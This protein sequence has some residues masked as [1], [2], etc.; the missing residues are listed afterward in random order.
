VGGHSFF[1]ASSP[2]LRFYARSNYEEEIAKDL[3]AP[4][5]FDKKFF[6]QRFS[7]DDVR[8]FKPDVTID[9]RTELNIGGTR[10]ELIPVEGGETHDSMFVHFPDLGA[11]FVGDF[12]MPYLGAPFLA[13]GNLP[14]LLDAID[15][16]VDKQPRHLLHGHEPLT[17]NFSS[18]SILARLKTHLVWLREQVLSAIRRGDERAAIHQANLIPPG[19]RVSSVF[20]PA[21]TRC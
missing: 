19:R 2:R 16:V 1:R 3:N 14:G 6:G 17:R 4:G 18:S 10:I 8:S 9:R 11:I 15:V 21:G 12:M 20:C 13:E 7:L 5:L